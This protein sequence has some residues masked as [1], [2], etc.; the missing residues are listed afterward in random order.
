MPKPISASAVLRQHMP[1]VIRG[2]NNYV[3]NTREPIPT[4]NSFSVLQE[5]QPVSNNYRNRSNSFKRKHLDPPTFADIVNNSNGSA[6]GSVSQRDTVNKVTVNIA[7]V[8]S[9][10]DKVADEIRN[11]DLDPAL[12]TVF[13]FLCEAVNTISDMQGKIVTNLIGKSDDPGYVDPGDNEGFITMGGSFPSSDMRSLGAIPK[14]PRPEVSR[15]MNQEP[16]VPD[17]NIQRN[18]A[19]SDGSDRNA[20]RIRAPSFKNVL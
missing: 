3:G 8:R 2:A 17:W 10:M 4:A 12:I 5:L 15:I 7:K 18:R 14:K 1:R 13:G 6:S 11:L 9:I 16:D 19:A 20:Q